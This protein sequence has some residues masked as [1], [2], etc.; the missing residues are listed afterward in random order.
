MQKALI[1][2][3]QNPSAPPGADQKGD[4]EPPAEQQ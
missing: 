4:Q 1:D 3:G 2:A